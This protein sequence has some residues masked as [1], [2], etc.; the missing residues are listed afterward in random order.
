MSRSC[1]TNGGEEEHLEVIGV[2]SRRKEN[3]RWVLKWIWV[4]RDGGS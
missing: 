3:T 4:R 2:K 1:I